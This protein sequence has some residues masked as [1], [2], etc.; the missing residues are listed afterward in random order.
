MFFVFVCIIALFIFNFYISKKLENA[1][2]NEFSTIKNICT[3][4]T[5]KVDELKNI[6]QD[7]ENEIFRLRE[8]LMEL[9]YHK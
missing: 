3:D 7:Q 1:L 4:S 2:D 6:L 5:N 9:K 8:K